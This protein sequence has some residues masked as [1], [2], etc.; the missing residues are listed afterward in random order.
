MQK[1]QTKLSLDSGEQISIEKTE[2]LITAHKTTFSTYW[3]WVYEQSNQYKEGVPLITNDG[4][5]LFCDNP[6]MTS[7]RNFPVQANAASITRLAIVKL[8]SEKIRVMCGLHDA[9]YAI[10]KVKD[11]D[12]TIKHVEDV[13][14]ESTKIILKEESTRIMIDTKIIT[15]EDLWV[16]EK[17]HNDMLNLA[18]LLG[19]SYT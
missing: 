10:C 15:H 14:K 1:L 11:M 16:E 9:V 2:E 3:K 8:V 6:I 18:P 17:G 5:V 7:V 12:K 13:M 19:L 4:F